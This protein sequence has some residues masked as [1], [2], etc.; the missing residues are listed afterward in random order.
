MCIYFLFCPFP[1]EVVSQMNKDWLILSQKFSEQCRENS[2]LSKALRAMQRSQREAHEKLQRAQVENR[3]KVIS[4]ED[5]LAR[6]QEEEEEE[7]EE[8][9]A[10]GSD[11]E[12][13][14]GRDVKVLQVSYFKILSG[15]MSLCHW[16]ASTVCLS[17]RPSIRPSSVVIPQFQ[18][19][20]YPILFP[21]AIYDSTRWGIQNFYAEF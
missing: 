1:R 19:A 7:E 13:D 11:E 17:V 10:E 15:R 9:E 5:E 3:Q 18:N 12:E 21:F 2:M 14:D 8:E 4:L 20:S 6:M 16:E